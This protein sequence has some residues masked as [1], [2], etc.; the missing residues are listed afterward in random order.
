MA[1]SR[2]Y[3]QPQQANDEPQRTICDLRGGFFWTKKK[4]MKIFR[5]LKKN[6]ICS[7]CHRRGL[8][9]CKCWLTTLRIARKLYANVQ[10]HLVGGEFQELRVCI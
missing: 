8:K 10:A 4:I 6:K 3:L 1:G 7:A 5:K 9:V 2:T